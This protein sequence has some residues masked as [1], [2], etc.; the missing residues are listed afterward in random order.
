MHACLHIFLQ[1]SCK[2]CFNGGREKAFE[3][4]AMKYSQN[5]VN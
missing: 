2:Q 3:R 1:I 5:Q 4:F